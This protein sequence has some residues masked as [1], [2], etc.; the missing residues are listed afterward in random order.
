MK[1][2]IWLALAV[3]LL[4]Q[5][6]TMPMVLADSD[7][8]YFSG[9]QGYY[10]NDEY[11]AFGGVTVRR[12]FGRPY[13][14]YS[15]GMTD[16]LYTDSPLEIT[17]G[18]YYSAYG[19]EGA[20]INFFD[21]ASNH[22]IT[23]PYA[24]LGVN[25]EDFDVYRYGTS[26]QN[27]NTSFKG[28]GG[29]NDEVI[30][31]FR[32]PLV[33]STTIS[34]QLPFYVAYVAHRF[35]TV[36]FHIPEGVMDET[37][38]TYVT[39]EGGSVTPPALPDTHA[40]D[41]DSYLEVNEAQDIY[42]YSLCTSHMAVTDAAVTATCTEPGLTRGSHCSVCHEVI[43]PQEVVPAKGHTVVIDAAVAPSGSDPG[44]SEGSH[45]S[46]CGTVFVPQRVLTFAGKCGSNARWEL[47]ENGLMT[48]SGTGYVTGRDGGSVFPQYVLDNTR[49]ITFEE[50]LT[51]ISGGAFVGFTALERVD[52]PASLV[53]IGNQ[54]GSG[55]VYAD[56]PFSGCI[57]LTEFDVS[58]DNPAFSA[59]DGMLCDCDVKRLY[60]CPPGRTG[61]AAIPGG[62]THIGSKAFAG[63]TSLSGITFTY[64]ISSIA[65]DA[66]TGCLSTLN[67]EVPDGSYA[68]SYAVSTGKTYT[69]FDL[70]EYT[71]DGHTVT[72][73]RYKGNDT[74]VRVPAEIFDL[75]V[76]Q[77]GISAFSGNIR[78]A[79]S[80]IEQII[81]PESI[82]SIG[83]YAFAHCNDL[84]RV[85]MPEQ[86]T[87]I[88]NSAF[89][90]CRNL[91]ELDLPDGIT[92]I[93][94][95]AF[96]NS[97]V[98]LRAALN[99]NL[100]R[101]LSKV[102]YAFWVPETDYSLRYVMTDGAVTGLELC[103]TTVDS[104][105]FTVPD[106]ITAIANSAFSGKKGLT[107]IVLHG[108]VTA[109]GSSAFSNCDGLRYAVI[110]NG[111]CTIGENAFKGC[112]QLRQ[113]SYGGRNVVSDSAIIG[114]GRCGDDALWYV[115]L[116]GR[117]VIRGSGAMYDYSYVSGDYGTYTTNEPWYY[118]RTNVG[119]LT[120][121]EDI[122]YIGTSAFA[123]M[124]ISDIEMPVSV[125][126][127]GSNA[128]QSNRANVHYIPTADNRSLVQNYGGTLTWV[129]PS[130]SLGNDAS[131]HMD[132]ERTLV[133][134]GPGAITEAG[135]PEY[136][137]NVNTVVLTESVSGLSGGVLSQL[138]VHKV[139]FLCGP[140]GIEDDALSGLTHVAAFYRHGCGWTGDARSRF[141]KGLHWMMC[142][143]WRDGDVISASIEQIEAVAP[144]C[145]D[146]GL[147]ECWRC[148]VCNTGF[149]DAEANEVLPEEGYIISALGH[150][151]DVPVYVWETDGSACMA[152]FTCAR[153]GEA[154]TAVAEITSEHLTEPDCETVGRSACTAKV[155][156]LDEQYTDTAEFDNL[157]ALGHDWTEVQVE[158]ADDGHAATAS[159]TCKRDADHIE[160][161]TVDAQGT[162]TAEPTWNIMGQTTFTATFTNPDFGVQTLVLSNL[163]TV[164]LEGTW[165]SCTWT[166][167]D[168]ALTV[169]SGT[170]TATGGTSPWV[171]YAKDI[172]QATFGSGVALPADVSG[173]FD[174]FSALTSI[175]F[176]GLKASRVLN[177]SAMFRGCAALTEINLTALNTL[178]A[179]SMGDMF[180]GCDALSRVTLGPSFRFRGSSALLPSNVLWRDDNGDEWSALEVAYRAVTGTLECDADVS[181]WGTCPMKYD[182]DTLYVYAGTGVNTNT[183]LGDVYP[184][185]L[186]GVNDSTRRLV[187]RMGV[188]FPGSMMYLIYNMSALEDV[189]FEEGV[190]TSN[191]TTMS[192]AFANYQS[193]VLNRFDLTGV[194][195]ENV[196][197]TSDMF[198]GR[199]D[200]SVK[201][202]IL[203][204]GF[205]C[206]NVTDMEYM[207]S[208]MPEL[209]TLDL[210]YF[211]P[212][213]AIKANS[214]F[215]GCKSLESLDLSGKDFSRA[216][217][218]YSMFSECDSL[219]TLDLTGTKLPQSF[220]IS[221]QIPNLEVLNV[222][223]NTALPESFFKALPEKNEGGK[224][225]FSMDAQRMCTADEL[226]AAVKDGATG[227][228]IRCAIALPDTTPI[229]YDGMEHALAVIMD[230]PEGCHVLY[231]ADGNDPW[232]AE[233]PAFADASPEGQPHRVSVRVVMDGQP[234]SDTYFTLEQ[235][236]EPLD[237]SNAK[238]I[239]IPAKMM[240]TG[241]PRIPD[242]R[243]EMT[244]TL[245]PVCEIVVTNN[246]E[247][248]TATL[249][250]T[251]TGN[252]TG[253][254]SGTFG[255]I[256]VDDAGMLK[257]PVS[258]KTVFEEAF[259]D[260][261][262][263][264]VI[265]PKDCVSIGSRA[266]ADSKNLLTIII[267]D[268][269][270]SIA[271]DAFDGVPDLSIQAS[272][273][274]YAH[275][276]AEDHGIHFDVLS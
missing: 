103:G 35:Y 75:P 45:C 49:R 146:T 240:Y 48:I 10:L 237:I 267:P 101:A 53:I 209:R 169:Q 171:S 217:S 86:L 246:I 206:E 50:G 19:G 24:R 130:G 20:I 127:I 153:C 27:I 263:Q 64:E 255:I 219:K 170:G 40:W 245:N 234:T 218:S 123:C 5:L 60:R 100:A 256:A 243:L 208:W 238:L 144:T 162:K 150:N 193:I 109:I 152:T 182:D 269:V 42:A 102:G 231:S 39:T 116:D 223:P 94:S 22:R 1:K 261:A 80:R 108:G 202:V 137:A 31:F 77:I 95:S 276:Y 195:T 239:L 72:I 141:G 224:G 212:S 96:D 63:C 252:Y 13:Y 135:W 190:D 26:P 160:T 142:C 111:G 97:A 186:N 139:V 99:T 14:V 187:F 118:L 47:D 44:L 61:K 248:G 148:A 46:V 120:I 200:H 124:G 216:T 105:D 71:D 266:F 138:P 236:I 110:E 122:T 55:L 129:M 191:V 89:I 178:A 132:N 98:S 33:P 76:T 258:L 213:S 93:G 226:Y 81:L 38:I 201:E 244:G 166:L 155:L 6:L 113:L 43:F 133:L 34:D 54:A 183:S 172:R 119:A 7:Y 88:G 125:S 78:S 17:K 194:T 62:V 270:T 25:D 161:E 37:E 181:L 82:T 222:G 83:D 15:V 228:L 167:R 179:T 9:K 214:L 207:F 65:S 188:V 227:I 173:L 131:W 73:N 259:A 265:L 230:G 58:D 158:W 198:H 215:S 253:T 199:N 197:D 115:T 136:A 28:F 174:G 189:I 184:W 70:Y 11:V 85:N 74:V 262:A 151:W 274:S 90:Y 104:G 147:A 106:N 4:I 164:P 52:I 112:T 254:L 210:T 273:G 140:E 56:D 192:Y 165:G 176:S 205:T 18:P 233:A 21:G 3:A 232:T 154:Q 84:V 91:T 225:W 159:R 175:D 196:T 180:N 185:N 2:T 87:S 128:F 203:G 117:L 66:F 29:D 121:S 8:S 257:L 229:T 114:L 204:P 68:L 16:T 272:T 79:N 69:K 36:T 268:S 12:A 221:E 249:T 250:F 177:A 59:V 211:N 32:L 264:M 242:Y 51:R 275:Q 235:V 92:S 41:S 143:D 156:F 168:G 134:T 163:P 247:P 23:L 157:P 260:T 220:T 57:K 241:Q 271:D 126:A 251:G 67:F 30:H 149:A 145:T 107:G